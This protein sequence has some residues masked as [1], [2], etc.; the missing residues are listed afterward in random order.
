MIQGNGLVSGHGVGEGLAF[1]RRWMAKGISHKQVV[2]THIHMVH[3]RG[4]AYLG[5]LFMLEKRKEREI[6]RKYMNLR[7][8]AILVSM[9]VLSF[10][11]LL[12]RRTRQSRQ[13][14]FLLINLLPLGKKWGTFRIHRARN[15]ARLY[16]CGMSIKYLYEARDNDQ[17]T[18]DFFHF[19]LS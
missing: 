11:P 3:C 15:P 13:D 16:E 5:C 8:H 10:R 14:Q 19:L 12:T 4:S 2:F 6:E 1:K 9:L 7:I 18:D 17:D